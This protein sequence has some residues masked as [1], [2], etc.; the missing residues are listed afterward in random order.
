MNN[1]GGSYCVQL[2]F[3]GLHILDLLPHGHNIIH[4]LVRWILL[5]QRWSSGTIN[6]LIE[7]Y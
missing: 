6:K 7:V 5:A 4:L 3:A 2:S 1:N